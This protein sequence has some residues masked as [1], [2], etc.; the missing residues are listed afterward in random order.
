[1]EPALVL[2]SGLICWLFVAE[3]FF[4]FLKAERQLFVKGGLQNVPLW[5]HSA[6]ATGCRELLCAMSE[7][8]GYT[9]GAWQG[10]APCLPGRQL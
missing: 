8:A 2:S 3:E 4:F 1:M 9:V 10:A 7:A 6:H 5:K